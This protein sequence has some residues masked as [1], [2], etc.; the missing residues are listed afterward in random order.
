MTFT[1]EELEI[2]TIAICHIAF[3]VTE[4]ENQS[5][6][7]IDREILFALEDRLLKARNQAFSVL[8]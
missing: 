8:S 5:G 3:N 7:V 2:I 4:A 6:E 1:E